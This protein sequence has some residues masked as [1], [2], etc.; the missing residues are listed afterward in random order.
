MSLQSD[1]RSKTSTQCN[2]EF[3][4][5]QVVELRVLFFALSLSPFWAVIIFPVSIS[6]LPQLFM[7][8]MQSLI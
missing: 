3:K 5:L 1:R 8:S 2:N 6:L 4:K 7:F